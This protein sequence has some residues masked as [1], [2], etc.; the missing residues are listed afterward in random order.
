MFGWLDLD[1]WDGTIHGWVVFGW[2][3]GLDLIGLEREY[4]M[5]MLDF[6]APIKSC[7]PADP[8]ARTSA[9]ERD[10]VLPLTPPRSSPL[11]FYRGSGIE[12]LHPSP[13]IAGLPSRLP[14]ALPRQ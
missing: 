14:V 1:G 5:E 4:F 9:F 7:V 10:V 8:L 12:R 3:I 11:A 2:R 13:L 6:S